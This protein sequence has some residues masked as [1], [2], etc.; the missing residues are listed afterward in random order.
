MCV[1]VLELIKTCLLSWA[2]L[3]SVAAL[4]V[5]NYTLSSSYEMLN[6]VCKCAYRYSLTRCM[7]THPQTHAHTFAHT[8]RLTPSPFYG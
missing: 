8:L 5:F 6:S 7:H 4:C 2:E 3:Q 1:K